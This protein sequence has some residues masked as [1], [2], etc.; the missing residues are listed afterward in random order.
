MLFHELIF[1][2]TYGMRI[3]QILNRRDE[4]K[5]FVKKASIEK[6]VS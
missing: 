4:L 2:A 3:L 5:E 6:D 1:I